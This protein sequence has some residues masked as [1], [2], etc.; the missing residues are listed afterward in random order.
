ME[1][2]ANGTIVESDVHVPAPAPAPALPVSK[3]S[4]ASSSFPNGET[5]PLDEVAA[6][7]SNAT[8]AE[9]ISDPAEQVPFSPTA[10]TAAHVSN[11]TGAEAISDPA[12]QAPLSPTAG[13]AANGSTATGAEATSDPAE[14]APSSPTAGTAEAPTE[15]VRPQPNTLTPPAAGDLIRRARR[16][17]RADHS[18]LASISRDLLKV[19]SEVDSTEQSLLGRV[20]DVQ[21]AEG[22]YAEH[23]RVEAANE[24]ARADIA[25]LNVQ[26]E[27]L[28]QQLLEA[29]KVFVAARDARSLAENELRAQEA[30][31]NA[32]LQT[33]GE[34]MSREREVE[35]EHR[36]LVE[37]QRPLLEEK[38]RLVHARQEVQVAKKAAQGEDEL[39]RQLRQSIREAH[40]DGEI[41][42]ARATELRKDLEAARFAARPQE[43]AAAVVTA[44]HSEALAKA[45]V[46]RLRAEAA[47]LRDEIRQEE[48]AA[49]QTIVA[50][51]QAKAD[52][53]TLQASIIAS[54]RDMHAKMSV[55]QERTKSAQESLKQNVG[56]EDEDVSH[57]QGL[58][59]QLRALQQRL[60]PVT[61]ASL[62]AENDAY[63]AELAQA[64]ELLEESKAAE[65]RAVAAAHQVQAEVASQRRAVA[66]AAES[67]TIARE[68]GH[69]QLQEAV[70]AAAADKVQSQAALNRA[71]GV[72]TERCKSD[73]DARS[74]EKERELAQCRSLK[75]SLSV[76]KA[77]VET[78]KQSL[79]AQQTAAGLG[80]AG[81]DSQ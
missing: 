63:G 46:Q 10:G 41:C 15:V 39:D 30:M 53:G 35:A 23:E 51:G 75:E 49:K 24:R 4:S 62:E 80:A 68:E 19:Q 34:E 81:E 59:A 25:R 56:V 6:N 54:V 43:S 79:Q 7:V 58:E 26:V 57:K 22:L 14:Q 13:T 77:E 5:L 29:Q 32:T 16:R 55:A 70:A 38:A 65:A 18:S 37:A 28:S 9:A 31:R 73:W 50:V 27:S 45:G 40:L 1:S 8:G 78:L 47:L 74:A 60:S 69:S 20:V 12:E 33:L 67:V 48:A 21:A 52:F 72:V 36:S 61:I 3:R 71:E 17:L 42:H 66:A 44:K 2:S 64:L 11:T 76:Q